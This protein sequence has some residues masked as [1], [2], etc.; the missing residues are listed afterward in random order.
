MFNKHA[1]TQSHQL[2]SFTKRNYLLYFY[3]VLDRSQDQPYDDTW[4]DLHHLKAPHPKS[5]PVRV[6]RATQELALAQESQYMCPAPSLITRR[7]TRRRLWPTHSYIRVNLLH[8][9]GTHHFSQHFLHTLSQFHYWLERRSANVPVGTFLST[10]KTHRR[11]AGSSYRYIGVFFA[12]V[13]TQPFSPERS[14]II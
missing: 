12:I 9:Q 11:R 4:L 8:P 7:I 3:I 14:Y 10:T 2:Y 13:V 6:D 1:F 5:M